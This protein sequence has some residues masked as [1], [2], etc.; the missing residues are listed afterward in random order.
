MGTYNK[1]EEAVLHAFTMKLI[2]DSQK[3]DCTIMS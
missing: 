3:I 2:D 1:K